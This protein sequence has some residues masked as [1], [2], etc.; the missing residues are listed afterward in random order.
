LAFG[1]PHESQPEAVE[2]GAFVRDVAGFLRRLLGEGATVEVV[3]GD[4]PLA[5]LVARAETGR[6][7]LAHALAVPQAR[8]LELG[9]ARREPGDTIELWLSAGADAPRLVLSFPAL[10]EPPE[11]DAAPPPA[12]SSLEARGSETVL[13]LEHDRELRQA[14]CRMLEAAGYRALEAEDEE[15]ALGLGLEGGVPIDLLLT[16]VAHEA[17]YERLRAAHTGLCRWQQA[18]PFSGPELQRAVR[19]ALD[20]RIGRSHAAL[21]DAE[22]VLALV[23]DDDPLVRLALSRI[24]DDAGADVVT[25]PSGLH[26]LQKLASLPVDLV[27]ADQ[28]MPGM[29]G[30]RLLE[31]VYR[32]WPRVARV[33]YTGYLS[34]GLVVDAVNR[35]SVH[36]V[37]AKDMAP[38]ALRAQLGEVIAE[39]RQ[40]RGLT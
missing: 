30:T 16:T 3:S 29:E 18:R 31:T 17:L 11:A 22:R 40:Q 2:L 25:A 13:V 35:A 32:Q 33:V 4:A 38:E 36:K 5:A 14:M 15:T 7:L 24:L 10:G 21:V 6:R 28:A 8:R 19:A 37:L 34:S 20:E 39:I 1:H 23:V 9:I 12:D 27:I 26:A